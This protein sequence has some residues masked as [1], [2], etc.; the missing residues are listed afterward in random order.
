MIPYEKEQLEKSAKEL[1]KIEQEMN[2]WITAI[3]R[4]QG[5]CEIIRQ[6]MYNSMNHEKFNDQQD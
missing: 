6:R 3:K 4:V 5:E 1:L 2:S